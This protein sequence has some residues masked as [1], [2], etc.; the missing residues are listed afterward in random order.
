MPSGL[1][2]TPGQ[3]VTLNVTFAPAAAGSVTGSV[4][5][6]SNASNSPATIALNGLGVALSSGPL[7]GQPN[8]KLVHVP[9]N[10][11]A[12][13]PPAKG[14]SYVDPVF[15]CT[16]TRLTDASSEDPTGDGH[17][18]AVHHYYATL[19][20]V[21]AND[22]MLLLDDDWG[23]W[24]VT[25]VNGNIVVPKSNMPSGNNGTRLWDASDPNAFYY[26]SGQSLMKGTISGSSVIAATVHQFSEYA[27]INFLDENDLS[28]DGAH[29]V[30]VGGD[31]T[32]ASPENVFDYNFAANTK[33]PVYT[34]TC[35]GPVN[36]PNN[37]CLH[38]LVQTADNN[39]IIQFAGEGSGAEQGNRL[40]NG[41]TPLPHM[42]DATS[43]LDAGYDILGNPV[44]ITMNNSFTL[45]G[46]TNPCPS[47]WGLDVRSI[48]NI[49]SAVCLLDNLPSWHASYRGG[50][51]Q[52]WVALSF[53]DYGRTQSSE[54]FN[55]NSNY[56]AP[57]ASNW[58]LYEDEIILAR[59]DGSAIYRLA[60]ARSRSMVDFWATPRAAISRDGKYVVFDS[61]MA[62]PNG[63]P[64]NMHVL[65]ECSDA[66][67]I[68]VQ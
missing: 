22:S 58:Q 42:Q 62:F 16:I 45:A 61:N 19:S 54:W 29:V 6:V 18:L 53:F 5:V 13:V 14:G 7:C 21:N 67:L 11:A 44:F 35:H 31:N 34:T 56:A 1:I 27:A 46:L 20:P 32:G 33:G 40:W 51:N 38:K 55:T 24:F 17:F 4:S 25:D 30:I 15:G 28:Q 39:I 49:T 65:T 37:S 64:S 68:K 63:C 26:T 36:G 47:G 66:Y 2:V 12:F 48:Y 57:S 10:W 3:T 9:P 50:P 52:P 23:G 43:H 8:D 59:V 60:H 41:T